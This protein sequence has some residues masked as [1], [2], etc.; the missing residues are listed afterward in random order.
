[1]SG[2]LLACLLFCFSLTGCA[3]LGYLLQ[4]GKGQLEISNR[5]KPIDE[6]LKDE[7]TPPRLKALLARIPEI[8][9]FGERHGLKATSNYTEYVDLKRPAAVWV[10]SASEPLKFEPRRWSFPIVGSFTY[11]G[12]FDRK[13][14]EEFGEELRKEGLD[15]YVRGASA[16]STL[17]WFRDPVLS[18]MIGSGDTALGELA[19]VVLH[20]SVHATFYL[21]HQSYFNESLASFVADRM[22]PQYL[23]SA[24][25]VTRA[26]VDSYVEAEAAGASVHARLREAECALRIREDG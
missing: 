13:S 11:L 7:R 23:A 3:G 1:M 16:F 12:W 4:A 6:V 25:L 15:V 2:Y 10:V 20:E 21:K 26:E 14:A 9:S 8:K 5:A 19:N 22:T 17:G 18:T 24:P